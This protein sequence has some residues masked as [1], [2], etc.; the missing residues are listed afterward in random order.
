MSASTSRAY[1]GQRV[2]KPVRW[3]L[4]AVILSEVLMVTGAIMTYRSGGWTFTS[5]G[6]AFMSVIGLGGVIETLVRRIELTDDELVVTDLFS[7]KRYARSEIARIEELKG[8][9]PGLHLRDGRFAKLPS[10][11]VPLGN[12]IRA[13]LRGAG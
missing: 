12:S 13:W 9:D 3:F 7:R 2:F 5:I 11:G 8:V 4:I 1:G 6:L 10:L